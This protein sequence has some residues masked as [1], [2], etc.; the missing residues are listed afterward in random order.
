MEN[1]PWGIF[2]N[3]SKFLIFFFLFFVLFFL[4][5]ILTEWNPDKITSAR[6]GTDASDHQVYYLLQYCECQQK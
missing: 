6:R 3:E 2:V 5:G 4:K 1:V